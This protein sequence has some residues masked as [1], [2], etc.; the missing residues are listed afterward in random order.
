MHKDF[1]SVRLSV[2]VFISETMKW[3]LMAPIRCVPGAHSLGVKRP[4][5]EADYSPP[6]SAEVKNAWSYNSTLPIR[7][8][9]VVLR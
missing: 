6:P 9:G 1:V 5:R 4:E 3:I 2:S 7:P 8:H